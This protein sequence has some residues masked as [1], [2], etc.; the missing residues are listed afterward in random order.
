MRV[1]IDAGHGMSNRAQGRYDPG[2]VFRGVSEADIV[3]LWALAGRYIAKTEFAG[4]VETWLTRD[5][6][7]DPAPVGVRASRASRGDCGLFLSLHCNAS[8]FPFVSGTETFYRDD[9]DFDWCDIVHAS[10]LATIGGRD[11]KTK[12]ESLSQ[13]ASLAVLG[14]G[15]PACLLELEFGTNPGALKRMLDRDRRVAFWRRVFT[16]VTAPGNA[17]RLS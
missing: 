1:A 17:R 9:R 14:F 11:R 10:A 2:A 5:D 7:E 15:P 12:H 16:A 8:A 13:H 6:A 4:K 3:L